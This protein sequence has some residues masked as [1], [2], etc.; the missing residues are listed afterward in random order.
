[1]F[2]LWV[3]GFAVAL[4]LLAAASSLHLLESLNDSILAV[5]TSHCAGWGDLAMSVLWLKWVA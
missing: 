3:M 5:I 2:S 1:M 4:D